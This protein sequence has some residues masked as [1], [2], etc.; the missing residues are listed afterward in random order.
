[1][2]TLGAPGRL[3]RAF[4]EPQDG[5]VTSS[6]R[7]DES[8]RHAPRRPDSTDPDLAPLPP[9]TDTG[10]LPAY[11]DEPAAVAT[12]DDLRYDDGTLDDGTLDDAGDPE[13]EETGLEASREPAAQAVAARLSRRPRDMILSVGLLLIVVFSLFGL[14]RC[15]GGDDTTAVDPRPAYAEARDAGAFPVLEP[16]GLA[17]GWESVSAAYQPQSGGAVLRVGWRT[18][19]DGTMQLVESNVAPDILLTRELGADA[20]PTG[21]VAD[22]N[23]RQWQVYEARDG[24]RA[25]VAQEAQRTIIVIGSASEDELRQFAA[26][27]K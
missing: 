15:L 20:R 13:I 23:D 3:A 19:A 16:T 14:Y 25:L 4:S 27:L 10:P 6:P 17:D 5:T 9:I 22:I 24:D 18:P 8:G 2:S 21:D 11:H 7:P 12:D 1:M 26:A